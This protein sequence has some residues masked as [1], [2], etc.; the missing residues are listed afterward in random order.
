MFLEARHDKIYTK[1]GK[2]I[3]SVSHTDKH[4]DLIDCKDWD[5]IN[6]SWHEYYSR[7]IP[8]RETE[9]KKKCDL[10]QKLCDAYNEKYGNNDNY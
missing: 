9:E 6:E 10:A 3:A 4:T 7:R 5:K 1:Q 8:L 2:Y